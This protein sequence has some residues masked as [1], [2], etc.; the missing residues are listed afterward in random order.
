MAQHIW[1]IDQ[2]LFDCRPCNLR[3]V[4]AYF[5]IRRPQRLKTIHCHRRA[6]WDM[7]TR[8]ESERMLFIGTRY[9]N[10]YTAVD[11]PAEAAWNSA[12]CTLLKYA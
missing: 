1:E 6:M 2:S 3:S 12:P 4:R 10:L 5:L 7:R 9:S 8:V 11:T